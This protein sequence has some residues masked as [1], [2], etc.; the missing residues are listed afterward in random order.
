MKTQITPD[1]VRLWLS[2]SDTSSWAHRPGQHWPCSE[3][4][5]R[6]LFAAFDR[7]GLYDMSIDGKSVD[8]DA[9]EFNAITSDFL[10]GKLPR[11]HPAYPVAVGQYQPAN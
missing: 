8:V 9:T 6:R 2:A 11:N 3:I 7:N 10:R 1:S 5:G 4:R